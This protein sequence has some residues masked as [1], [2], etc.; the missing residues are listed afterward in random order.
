MNGSYWF[1]QYESSD[2]RLDTVQPGN[3]YNLLAF[4]NLAPQY[5][6]NVFRVSVRYQF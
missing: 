3:V 5:R 1:E 6:V 4:G 2:W